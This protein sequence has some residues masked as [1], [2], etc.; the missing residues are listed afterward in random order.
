MKFFLAFILIQ[1]ACTTQ[2]EAPMSGQ[3]CKMIDKH[4]VCAPKKTRVFD[5]D[6]NESLTNED[7]EQL[8]GG[9]KNGRK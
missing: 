9:R 8:T 2:P 6:M 4:Y 7:I 5:Y 3:R 1:L